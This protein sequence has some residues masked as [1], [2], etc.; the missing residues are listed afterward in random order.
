M[1]VSFSVTYIGYRYTRVKIMRRIEYELDT[2][3]ADDILG[4]WKRAR[5]FTFYETNL[6]TFVEKNIPVSL[7]LVSMLNTVFVLY[8][9]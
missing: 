2:H 7:P 6:Y 8:T 5:E 9:E 3:E 1:Y 4:S